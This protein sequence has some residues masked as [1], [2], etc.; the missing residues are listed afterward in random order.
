MVQ[1]SS[2][3]VLSAIALGAISSVS[4]I[5]VRSTQGNTANAVKP[6]QR[7]ETPARPQQAVLQQQQPRPGTPAGAQPNSGKPKANGLP[8][9][10]ENTLKSQ[11]QAIEKM[12]QDD[13]RV[14]KQK[15][16]GFEVKFKAEEKEYK[17][18]EAEAQR[19]D[20]TSGRPQRTTQKAP[21]GLTP[22]PPVTPPA[23]S[24]PAA[25]ANPARPNTPP[26]PAANGALAATPGRPNTNANTKPSPQQQQLESQRTTLEKQKQKFATQ[27]TAEAKKYQAEAD[28]YRAEAQR[29]EPS[30]KKPTQPKPQTYQQDIAAQNAGL[31]TLETKF[32][33]EDRERVDKLKAETAAF[34]NQANQFAAGPGP[35]GYDEDEVFA[36]EWEEFVRREWEALEELD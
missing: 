10:V 5:P 25:N 21:R 7:V 1:T 3:V 13:A 17:A 20:P 29:L 11:N 15:A 33:T 6:A 31:K 22:K 35:R 4:A 18:Y 8:L 32:A 26:R 16:Q 30:P 14:D 12:K 9:S 24:R 23:V 19:L 36:R 27:D 2:F 34:A 28:A